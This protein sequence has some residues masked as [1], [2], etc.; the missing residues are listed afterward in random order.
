MAA[1]PIRDRRPSIAGLRR[2]ILGLLVAGA[3]ALVAVYLIGRSGRP[4]PPP[5]TAGSGAA[6][7]GD[8]TLIG[9]GFE[10]TQ[11]DKGRKVFRIR[12]DSLKVRRGTEMLLAG[13]GLTLYDQAGVPYEVTGKEA[14][15]DQQSRDAL[16]QGD[17]VLRGPSHVEL[18]TE[19]LKLEKGGNS[20]ES[21]GP[22]AFLYGQAYAG[23]AS[24]MRVHVARNFLQL[25]G[26]VRIDS[27]PGAEPPLS[28]RSAIVV[29]EREDHQVRADQDVELRRGLDVVRARRLNATLSDDDKTLEFLRA[30]WQVSGVVMLGGGEGGG[31]EPAA[32]DEHKP[33]EVDF[34]CEVL[35]VEMEA[36]G[37][38]PHS[39]EL[40]GALD[41]PLNLQTHSA[42]GPVDTLTAGYAVGTFAG[43]DLTK[44]EAFDHPHLSEAAAGAPDQPLRTLSSG[45]LV[46]GFA[47]GRLAVVDAE[48]E[49]DYRFADTHVTGDRLHYDA[50]SGH[51]EMFGAPLHA[52]SARGELTAPHAVFEEKAK[53]LTADGGVRA[54]LKEE[55][56][57]GLSGSPLAGGEGPVQV[58]AKEAL[59]RD[60][61]RSYVFRG[62]VRAWQG[63]NLLVASSLRGDQTA[64]GDDLTASGGVKTVWTPAP[65][66]GKGTAGAGAPVEIN[67]REMTYQR[68]EGLLEYHGDVRADQEGR[69]LTC[70]DLEVALD[71]KGKAKRMTCTGAVHL[72]DRAAGN[73]AEGDRAVYELTARTVEI[74]GAPVKLHKSD[75]TRVEGRRVLYDL[76]AGKA[77]VLS[78]PAAP[79]PSRRRRAARPPR[80]ARRPPP[81]AAEESGERRAAGVDHPQPAQG[82]PR[83]GGG[84]GRL[85]RGPPRADRRPA[86]PQRRRQDDHL[87]HG[88]GADAARLRQRPPRRRRHHRAGDVPA[89]GARDQL[90]AAGALGVPQDVGGGQPDGDLRDPRPL[91][92][93]AAAAGRPAHHR[94][95]AG[96][97]AQEP[98]LRAFRGRTAAGGDRPRAGHRPLVY[99]PRRAFCGDRPD[100]GARHPGY[101]QAPE[102]DGHR[103]PH[104]R[105]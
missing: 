103:D 56:A 52:L 58:E 17:V 59:W 3:L 84:Q 80:P 53:V 102:G 50:G 36:G 20:V 21:T 67:A 101:H 29:L 78:E 1:M 33:S 62:E 6:P 72:T 11:T 39:V 82:L 69:L 25:A 85:H 44:V 100:C 95:R 4:A 83:P 35:S 57:G 8:I 60:D 105:P 43:G 98:R 66:E 93:R 97:G 64:A 91:P 42:E 61:P 81:P 94:P 5:R 32:A 76:D 51:G 9:Q 27:L 86:R 71:D 37:K 28:L 31:D 55:G 19:G 70:R 48:K 18:A 23:R 99:P 79:R 77:R 49:V 34:R 15:Y 63:K 89:G 45:K 96:E 104:H 30:R 24:R 41:A 40:E 47:A 12:G 68:G 26:D 13:V 7:S 87:L 92:R 75:G 54:T 10:Y 46:A 74:D 73:S 90:P 22:V 14:T 88:G 16:L 38:A 65:E 2:L